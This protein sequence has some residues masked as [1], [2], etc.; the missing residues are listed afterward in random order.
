V[1]GDR[2]TRDVYTPAY[3]APERLR[4]DR[5]AAVDIFSIGCV[6]YEIIMGR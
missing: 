3:A 2:D 4:G 1:S 6:A 5:S